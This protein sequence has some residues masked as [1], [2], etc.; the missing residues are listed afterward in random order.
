MFAEKT[1]EILKRYVEERHGGTVL[2]ASKDLGLPNDTLN[3]WLRNE[4][5]PGLSKIGPVID[6]ILQGYA[7][8][9]NI[10]DL[11]VSFPVIVQNKEESTLQKKVEELEKKFEKVVAENNRLLGM[12]EVYEK[13]LPLREKIISQEVQRVKNC[14]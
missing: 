13:L 6:K 4:R 1:L 12:I 5:D 8:P 9:E 3:R 2:H 11:N 14:G 7:R 10:E